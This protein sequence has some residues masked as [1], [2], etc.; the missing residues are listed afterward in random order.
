MATDLNI[1]SS[2]LTEAFS[3]KVVS[4]EEKLG[5][6]TLVVKAAD[7]LSVFTRLRNDAEFSFE[8]L[9]DVCGIDYSTF[10]SETS[11]GG[12]Y[13]IDNERKGSRFAAIYHLLS[14]THN[15]RLRVRI[16]AEDDAMPMLDSVI[17]VWSAANWYEREAFDLYGIIFVGHPDLRLILTDYGFVGNPFR[18]D[19]PLSG[20][21]DMRYDAAQQRVVYE[22]VSIEPREITPRSLREENFG[23][24]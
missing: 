7:M 16:F 18:K 10:G 3:D 17:G 5:E 2:N 20:T 22:P 15:I 1:L 21:V 9:I 14:I 23:R 6:L 4:L 8:E 12:K 24:H 13:L 19:F 11:E